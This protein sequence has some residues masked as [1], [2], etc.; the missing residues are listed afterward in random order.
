MNGPTALRTRTP[1]EVMLR[2]VDAVTHDARALASGVGPS[3]LARRPSVRGWSAGECL[4]HLSLTM[5]AF[6]PRIDEGLRRASRAPAGYRPTMDLRGRLLAWM[7]EPPV[8][9]R[10]STTAPFVPGTRGDADTLQNFERLQEEF[11]VRL[12][13]SS[14]IDLNGI[15]IASPFT[16]RMS[17]NLFSC[18]RILLAHERRHLWQARRALQGVL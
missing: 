17:Y 18:Y 2:E 4:V 5:E 14:G 13:R 16:R 7:L 6:L 1:I 11:S 10:L 9:F 15:L 3:E 12:R 8:R